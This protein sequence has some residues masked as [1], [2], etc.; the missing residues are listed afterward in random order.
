MG[1]LAIAAGLAGGLLIKG[2]FVVLILLAIAVWLAIN[3]QRSEVPKVRSVLAVVAGLAAMAALRR[4][5]TPTT[6]Q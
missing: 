1:A 2:V 6:F 4:R 3:P 5:T